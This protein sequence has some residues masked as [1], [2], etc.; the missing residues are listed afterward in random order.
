[1]GGGTPTGGLGPT[2]MK[3]AGGVIPTGGLTGSG[4]T[5]NGLTGSGFVPIPCA[6]S[7][8]TD[9][10]MRRTDPARINLCLAILYN[11]IVPFSMTM[12]LGICRS[13]QIAQYIDSEGLM[14]LL[15]WRD[16][17]WIRQFA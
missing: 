3:G 13:Q 5:G 8:V 17:F 12:Q 10:P 16:H 4:L 2:G 15:R 14:D 9:A 11:I 6:K 7:P 1:M